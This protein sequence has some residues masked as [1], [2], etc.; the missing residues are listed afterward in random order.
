MHCIT[1]TMYSSRKNQI[2]EE[3]IAELYSDS[4]SDISDLESSNTETVGSN[5][6]N[7]IVW[8]SSQSFLENG[9]NIEPSCKDKCGSEITGKIQP[10]N[11]LQME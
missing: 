4:L 2:V 5:L 7:T 6:P 1:A 9:S 8:N 3:T 10:R 11:S